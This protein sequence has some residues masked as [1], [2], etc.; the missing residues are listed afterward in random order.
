MEIQIHW[1]NGIDAS[2]AL[3]A[4]VRAQVEHALRHVPNQFTRVDVHL[5][6]DNASKGGVDDKRC[7]IEAR[8]TS[9]RP[10]TVEGI[11]GD[12]YPTV[13]AAGKKLERVVQDFADKRRGH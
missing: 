12:F 10:L 7:V 6:D 13:S 11:G 9:A 1:A 4:H 2:D 5:H 3:S 8:P